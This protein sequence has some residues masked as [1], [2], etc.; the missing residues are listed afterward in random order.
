MR[1]NKQTEFSLTRSH[2][3]T[4]CVYKDSK[5]RQMSLILNRISSTIA[6]LSGTGTLCSTDYITVSMT[7]KLWVPPI[8]WQLRTHF[9]F[10]KATYICQKVRPVLKSLW[11]NLSDGILKLSKI[12]SFLKLYIKKM[13]QIHFGLEFRS[14]SWT[15]ILACLD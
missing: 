8:Y 15:N 12:G 5:Y 7:L 14:I 3:I 6:A 13:C 1:K 4:D 11:K 9:F 10:L 2:N